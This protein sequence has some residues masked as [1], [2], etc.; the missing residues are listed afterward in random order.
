MPAASSV[1]KPLTPSS[2]MSGMP[3]RDSATIGTPAAAASRRAIGW[4]STA[5]D[6]T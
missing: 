6:V 3:P 4:H 1:S 2:T 5:L